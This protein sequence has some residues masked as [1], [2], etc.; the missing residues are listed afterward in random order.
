VRRPRVIVEA[1]HAGHGKP[2]VGLH[3]PLV[4][5]VALEAARDPQDSLGD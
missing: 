3:I 5:V 1:D 4:G 2:P